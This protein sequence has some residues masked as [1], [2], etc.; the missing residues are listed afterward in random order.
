MWR[1]NCQGIESDRGY[2]EKEAPKGRPCPGFG[3]E[4][5]REPISSPERGWL[6][7]EKAKLKPN[8]LTG[9]DVAVTDFAQERAPLWEDG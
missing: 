3:G 2:A 9:E 4:T 5:L 1:A 7:E 6:L 8:S